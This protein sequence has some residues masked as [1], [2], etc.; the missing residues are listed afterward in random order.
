MEAFEDTIKMQYSKY[1]EFKF[2]VIPVNLYPTYNNGKIVRKAFG[3]D[4][5]FLKMYDIFKDK[6]IDLDIIDK[7]TSIQ[8][9][10]NFLN[11]NQLYNQF[12]SKNDFILTLKSKC[13]KIILK[14]SKSFLSKG[15]K[16]KEIQKMIKDIYNLYYDDNY[17]NF[18]FLISFRK[19]RF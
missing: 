7:M 13:T 6:I 9:L 12:K 19:K 11:E 17:V 3:L 15:N 16:E 14:Y 5:L 2:H 1:P 8:E 4:K 18:F 10:L